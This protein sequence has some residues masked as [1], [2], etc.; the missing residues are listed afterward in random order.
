MAVKVKGLRGGHSGLEIHTGRGNALKIATRVAMA[1]AG[2]GG[3]LA[4]F[5]GGNKRNAIPREAEAHFFVPKAKARRGDRA[6]SNGSTRR[7]K[8]ELAIG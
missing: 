5:E 2:L 4:K 3:R 1:I 6:W 8:A 7:V